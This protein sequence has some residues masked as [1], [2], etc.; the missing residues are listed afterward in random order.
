M[1]DPTA[2]PPTRPLDLED[3]KIT[4]DLADIDFAFAP[5]DL[6]FTWDPAEI[7]ELTAQPSSAA[8]PRMRRPRR[9]AR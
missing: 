7:A 1:S 6:D 8:P 2:A 5:A 3:L 4:W 9:G